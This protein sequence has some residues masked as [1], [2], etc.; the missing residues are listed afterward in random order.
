[1]RKLRISLIFLCLALHG[2][3]TPGGAASASNI[4]SPQS[5]AIT[6]G[7]GIS[8]IIVGKS[9]MSDV[10]AAY[11]GGFKLVEHNKYSYE[12]KYKDL[13]L[14]FYYC[15]DD[16]EK[17]IFSINIKPPCHG[18]T[19]KGII[20]GNSTLQDVFDLYGK[21]EPYTTIVQETWVFKYQGIEF[22]ID[23]DSKLKGVVDEIPEEILKKKII[24][25]AVRAPDRTGN[26]C[27][28]S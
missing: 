11:G 17:K 28:N 27:P 2:P 14:S 25:I 7:V 3:P 5:E 16:E 9:T 8:G 4:S 19:S 23:Y 10:V 6:E 21:A 26:A 13:G 20:V 22:H 1:M 15:Y 12:A 24:S 18:I